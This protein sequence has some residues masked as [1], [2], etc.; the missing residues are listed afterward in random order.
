[1]TALTEIVSDKTSGAKLFLVKTSFSGL[2]GS[3]KG[4]LKELDVTP[5]IAL[6]RSALTQAAYRAA[7]E[8]GDSTASMR[9]TNVAVLTAKRC[10]CASPSGS[11]IRRC[12]T[13]TTW[14]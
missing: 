1:M 8:K 7:C 11:R 2:M 9:V 3:I 13:T 4:G 5:E 12:V 10:W 14:A 6:E